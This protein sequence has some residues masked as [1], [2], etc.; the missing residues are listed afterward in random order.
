MFNNWNGS[1]HNV[2]LFLTIGKCSMHSHPLWTIKLIIY[3]KFCL[4]LVLKYSADLLNGSCISKFCYLQFCSILF[5]QS[6]FNNCC[7]FVYSA[8][9]CQIC[10]SY[11][12]IPLFQKLLPTNY[13]AMAVPVTYS[14]F[15]KLLPP[16][17]YATIVC[18]CSTYSFFPKLPPTQHYAAIVFQI[19]GYC[20][21]G[22]A[23]YQS[24]PHS[25]VCCNCL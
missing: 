1:L 17:H 16:Q 14:F 24:F 19:F 12:S 15:S 11:C 7:N 25:T 3:C 22:V 4:L 10:Y 23:S 21:T 2:V 5:F 18:Y 6:F 9:V 13:A 8:I 20:S